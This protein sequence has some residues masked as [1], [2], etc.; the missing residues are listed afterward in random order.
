MALHT[1]IQVLDPKDLNRIHS[2]TL[3]VLETVG[4]E[5][6]NKQAL[7]LFHAAGATVNGSRVMIPGKL[8]EAAI[9]SAPASFT[10]FAR[11]EKKS[12]TIGEGQTRT[13]VEPSNGNIYTLDLQRGRRLASL[14]DLIDFYKLAQASKICD[15][16]GGIPVEPSD[17]DPQNAHLTIFQ[18]TLRHTDK[19]IKRNVATRKEIETTFAMFEIAKG[20]KGYLREHPS[21]YASVNPLSPLAYDDVPLETIITYA[22]HNQPITVL[23]CAMAGVSA[24]MGL[25]GAAVLQNA[26]ILAGLVLTQIIRPGAP[27]IY[28]PATAVPNMQNAQ[29]VTGSP[30]SNLINLANI[31][32]AR[33]MYRLPTRTMAGLTDAK[34][35]DTQAG[36][37]TM[38]NLFQCMLGGVSIINECLGVLDSIMTNCYEKFILDEEMI[39]RILR[40]MEGMDT[41]QEELSVEVIRA[42]GPRGSFLTHPSTLQKCRNAWRPMVSDW[43]NYDHW[44]KNGKKEVVQVAAEK[45][46]EILS[47]CPETTL[48]PDAEAELA[49]FVKNKII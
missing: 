33:E 13:H 15:I 1:L 21:I 46:Q 19:P 9:E 36:L 11:D 10:L 17:I 37:E 30:E 40:F 7:S 20:V 14:S 35:V 18:E 32:L 27:F 48:N 4:V 43:G 2:S 3:E 38:Q 44:A 29:Y 34:T 28:A 42:V 47:S 6:K 49:A 45:V 8:V 25:M 22:E 26:E 39:S 24:P 23:S 41:S 12:L 31:Q 5:M 16:S